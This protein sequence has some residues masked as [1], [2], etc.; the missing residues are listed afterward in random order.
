MI[1][2]RF[3]AAMPIMAM[4]LSEHAGDVNASV[5]QP[6]QVRGLRTHNCKGLTISIIRSSLLLDWK[7]VLRSPL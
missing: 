3:G 4:S 1:R 6:L 2:Q 5:R 7:T